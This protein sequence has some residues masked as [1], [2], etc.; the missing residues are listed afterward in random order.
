MTKK[1]SY[2]KAF[3]ILNEAIDANITVEDAFITS[4]MAKADS[5]QHD[6]NNACTDTEET[7]ATN[8]RDTAIYDA[9]KHLLTLRRLET[10][11]GMLDA[12]RA[13]FDRNIK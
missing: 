7:R 6:L 10:L 1:K 11:R 3:K 12:F 8:E 2:R 9:E 4:F 5:A 13:E